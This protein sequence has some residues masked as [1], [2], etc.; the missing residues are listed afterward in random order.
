MATMEY[1][2]NINGSPAETG[3]QGL[4][5]LRAEEL[6]NLVLHGDAYD[7]LLQLPAASIDLIITSPPYWG[8]RDYG[9]DHNWDLFNDI[10]K[11]R[12]IGPVSPGYDW[13]RKEGG[14]LGLEPYPEWYVMHLAEIFTR[15]FNCL[16][17]D[18]NIWVN[19]G[20]TYFARWSSIRDNGRQGLADDDRYRRKTP[21]GGTRQEKQLLLIPSRF[22]I[23]MQERG[24]I[25][26]NDLIWYKPNGTPRPEGDRLKLSHEHFFHFV[27]KPKEGRATYFYQP[28]YAETR[29]ND[30]V[31]VNVTPG[32]EGH[33]ATFPHA[34]IEPRILT[35]SPVG[36]FVLDPF[37]GTGRALETAKRLGR[38]VI[39]FDA[40]GKFV[41]LTHN[42]LKGAMNEK[43]ESGNQKGNYV[44]EWFGQRIYP[45]VRLD[46]AAATG[47]RFGQ[48]PFLSD[49]L[50][51]S[52][53][54]V[55]SENA[56]GVCTISSTSNGS[57]QDWLVCPYRVIDSE[58]VKRGCALI[59]GLEHEV[60]PLPVSLL[61]H[62]GELDKFKTAVQKTGFGYL[63]FQDKLGGEISVLATEQSPEMAF[64]VTV[65][66][67]RH[68]AGNFQVS[69]YGI[70]EIQTMDFH[71]SYKHAVTNLRDALRLHEKDFPDALQ[72][73]P[74]WAGKYVEG[75]NIA[76]VFKRTFYQI[77]LKFKLSGQGAAAGT[78]LALPQSVW[79]SWQP[80]LGAPQLE[81]ESDGI[82]R[83]KIANGKHEREALNSYICVFDLDGSHKKSISPVVIKDFIRVSPDQ[84]AHHAFSE[85]PNHMLRAIQST[86]AVLTRIR[87]RLVEWWPDLQ[88]TGNI[89]KISRK[90]NY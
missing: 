60:Q 86:D 87:A 40:Q 10:L 69:R 58:I 5:H 7:L 62:E 6:H 31:A 50:K 44:S 30:V 59:F 78:V 27:K 71:G 32:E 82:K 43:I 9:L 19:V 18:G 13:Y 41:E 20:D 36:G 39:G 83:F 24:W 65:L 66:E 2:F 3:S 53:E 22:A 55:K 29:H 15:A 77:M 74:E 67:I 47:K 21:M 70:L 14:L 25:L 1:A 56:F 72:N 75:P 61:K 11:V 52:T 37:C 16:K 34:L 73:K 33:T 54:C 17:S 45:M 4:K 68:S 51:I 64:D 42:K 79:D 80:F 49:I 81:E 48:C 28:E 85:V 23:A 12:E 8:H 57:R 38:S 35:S 89:K 88:P 84:L 26:R 90:R 46:I 63:F 76:N